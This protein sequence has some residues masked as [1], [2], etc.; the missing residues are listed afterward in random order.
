MEDFRN[1]LSNVDKLER[2]PGLI[3]DMAIQ[4]LATAIN[5]PGI[6]TTVRMS[7]ESSKAGLEN[8]NSRSIQDNFKTIYSQM[9]ILAVSN[10][11][12]TLK[13]YFENAL[14]EF[15][16]INQTNED[17]NKFKISLAELVENNLKFSGEFGKLVLEKINLN[18]QDL[19]SIKRIFKDYI[20]KILTLDNATEKEICFYLEVRHVLVHKGGVVDAKFVQATNAFG[21][22][23]KSY[24]IGDHI[25]IDSND[26]DKIKNSFSKLVEN[27]TS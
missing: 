5:T 21:A 14:S 13:K 6:Q 3:K 23:L 27:V 24:S 8:I 2:T 11:E 1:E 9:C 7:L 26:W 25:E 19:K 22:N 20:S 10:L 12:A 15:S 16:N 4:A 17:L 18:F